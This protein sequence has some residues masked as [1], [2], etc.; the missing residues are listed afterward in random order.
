L[1]RCIPPLSD[2]L[3]PRLQGDQDTRTPDWDFAKLARVEPVYRSPSLLDKGSEGVVG[4]GGGRG[5]DFG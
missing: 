4:G 2:I 3:A 1:Q 5:A